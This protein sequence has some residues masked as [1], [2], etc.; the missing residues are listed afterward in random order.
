MLLILLPLDREIL[1]YIACLVALRR[2]MKRNTNRHS[3]ELQNPKIPS[4]VINGFYE[5]FT[6]TTRSNHV[7]VQTSYHIRRFTNTWVKAL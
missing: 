4:V 2:Q 1:A 3:V 5:R 7:S 6:E